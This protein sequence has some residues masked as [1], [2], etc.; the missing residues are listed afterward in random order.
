MSIVTGALAQ[1]IV[2]ALYAFIICLVVRAV[3][4]WFDPLVNNRIHRLAYSIVEPVVAPIRRRIQPHGG[5]FDLAF[6][7]VF[8]AAMI[9]VQVIQPF[10]GP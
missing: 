2:Y 4:S 8:V 3:F 6:L 1:L 9:L 5:F 10:A 7:L